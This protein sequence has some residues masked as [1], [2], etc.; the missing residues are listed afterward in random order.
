MFAYDTLIIDDLYDEL[1]DM[2]DEMDS[3]ETGVAMEAGDDTLTMEELEK[4][5]GNKQ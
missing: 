2:E 1:D 4:A 3:L 5:T